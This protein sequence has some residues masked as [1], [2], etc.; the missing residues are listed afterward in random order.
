MPMT[1]S[2]SQQTPNWPDWLGRDGA[3]KYLME[4]HGI[5]FGVAAL[6]NAAVKGTGPPFHKDGGKLV[7]YARPDLDEW[8]SKRKSRRVTSTSELRTGGDEPEAA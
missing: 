7:T 5:K 2:A 3:S 6:A 1:Q 8:A 4:A